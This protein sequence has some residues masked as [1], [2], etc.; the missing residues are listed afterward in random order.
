MWLV[1]LLLLPTMTVA[2][3]PCEKGVWEELWY[4]FRV[5]VAD[6]WFKNVGTPFH[7]GP[8]V[9]FP[10]R[11][12]GSHSV[13]RVCQQQFGVRT[14]W[15]V[16]FVGAGH[17]IGWHGMLA[18]N[19]ALG[20]RHEPPFFASLISVFQRVRLSTCASVPSGTATNLAAIAPSVCGPHVTER[21]KFRYVT[22][23]CCFFL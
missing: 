1:L 14:S 20:K 19:N 10:T 2:D 6:L 11:W 4:N 18:S 5:N 22:V 23:C 17:W 8:S 16:F 13:Q 21:G 3:K 15:D 7:L 12:I 9:S